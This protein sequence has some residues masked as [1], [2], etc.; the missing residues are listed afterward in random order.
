MRYIEKWNQLMKRFAVG[1]KEAIGVLRTS[2]RI[3][4]WSDGKALLLV[5]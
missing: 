4:L 5:I 2:G 1:G 3:G